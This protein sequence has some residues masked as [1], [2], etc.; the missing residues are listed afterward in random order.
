MVRHLR[1]H[2][3]SEFQPVENKDAR[4]VEKLTGSVTVKFK[5][6]GKETLGILVDSNTD[7]VKRWVQIALSWNMH[8][9]CRNICFLSL[10]AS[11]ATIDPL[12]FAFGTVANLSCSR[13]FYVACGPTCAEARYYGH[14]RLA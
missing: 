12:T 11:I 14:A 6:P 7:P 4:S 13:L 10:Q 5:A 8:A 3:D 9:I 1:N 2:R